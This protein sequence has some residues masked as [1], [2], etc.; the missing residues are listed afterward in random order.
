MLTPPD[1][2]RILI[3]LPNIG[4]AEVIINPFSINILGAENQLLTSIG[5]ICFPNLQGQWQYAHLAHLTSVNDTSCTVKLSSF[6]APETIYL[7][8]TAEWNSLLVKINANGNSNLN[9]LGLDLTSRNDEHFLG[10]GE[11]FNCLDQRGHEIN[12]YVQNSTTDGEVYKPIPFYC[13][14]AGY[15]LQ[16]LTDVFCSLHLGSEEKPGYVTIR[17]NVSLS[18]F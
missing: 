14:T 10:L 8:L 7:S 16:I 17:N 9:W 1:N 6:T 3:S 4:K 2:H 11:R 13:S 12:L 5:G 18:F 15:G